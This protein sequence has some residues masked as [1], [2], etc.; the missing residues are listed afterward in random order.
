MYCE[1]TKLGNSGREFNRTT[2]LLHSVILMK[3]AGFLV[4]CYL[5][6]LCFVYQM[7]CFKSVVHTL[8]FNSKVIF[9]FDSVLFV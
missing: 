4:G 6:L 8:V 3:W 9:H 2:T 7:I 5:V 1:T